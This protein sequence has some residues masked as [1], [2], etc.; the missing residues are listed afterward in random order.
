MCQS[1]GAIATV[2]QTKTDN[3]D[4]NGIPKGT[5]LVYLSPFGHL[6]KQKEFIKL[7]GRRIWD[8][9]IKL[10]DDAPKDLL[11]WNY[12]MTPMEAKVLDNYLNVKLK[13]SKI[14]PSNSPYAVPCFFIAKKDGSRRLVQDYRKVNK[15]TVKDKTPLLPINDLLDMLV[16]GKIYNKVDIIWGYNNV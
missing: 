1:K 11:A 16:E 2:T 5:K 3:L 4:E 7:P 14:Q 12:R 8:H 6:F 13:A 10:T 15:F 9:E